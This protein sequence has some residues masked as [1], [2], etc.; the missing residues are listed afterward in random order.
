MTLHQK[1]LLMVAGSCVF[2]FLIVLAG[3]YVYGL[4]MTESEPRPEPGV[5]ADETTG[6]IP[7]QLQLLGI[8]QFGSDHD[9]TPHSLAVDATGIYIVGDTEGDLEGTNAAGPEAVSTPNSADS[10]NTGQFS[11][12]GPHDAFVQK[13]SLDGKRKLWGRQFGTSAYDAARSVT[14]NDSG[15]YVAGTTE[16]SLNGEYQGFSDVFLNKYTLNG[17]LVWAKQFGTAQVDE[18]IWVVSDDERVCLGGG[19]VGKIGDTPK[20][21]DEDVFARCYDPEGNELWTLQFGT[22]KFEE[23]LGAAIDTT[24]IYVVG[25]TGGQIG[26]DDKVGNT[27]AWVGKISLDGELLFTEQF[28]SKAVDFGHGI[29]VDDQQLYAIGRTEGKI[30]GN[31]SVGGTDG[32]I[33]VLS[34]DGTRAIWND[35]FG[36]PAGDSGHDVAVMDGQLFAIGTVNGKDEKH[37]QETNREDGY[38]RQY[39]PTGKLMSET[40]LA[41]GAYD[42]PR[43]IIVANGI[44]YIVGRT[45]GAFAQTSSF[46]AWDIFLMR[47]SLTD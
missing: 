29:A 1:R 21:G 40:S 3:W 41:T 17:Q 24:G 44:A 30:P 25:A 31:K 38:L 28:G 18:A 39:S 4:S 45:G 15:V 13:Y 6:E 27:D 8:H 42:E 9:D 19:T 26:D 34:R 20:L 46:G 33:Q 23:T 22:E 11:L 10:R 37:G 36:S 47:Y 43:A 2:A 12:D 16:G 5:T 35:Q 32:F 7:G 14:A